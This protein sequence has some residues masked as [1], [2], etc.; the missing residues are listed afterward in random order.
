MSR[1]FVLLAAL[2][3]LTGVALGAFGA[4]G[5]KARVGP[6]LLEVWETA[7]RYQLIHALALL[8]TSWAASRRAITRAMASSSSTSSARTVARVIGNPDTIDC[9]ER[10]SGIGGAPVGTRPSG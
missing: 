3:G 2:F 5:L 8:A 9:S 10:L 4:H 7:A 1:P 6:E